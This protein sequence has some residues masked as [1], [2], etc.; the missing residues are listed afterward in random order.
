MSVKTCCKCKVEK[1]IIYFSKNKG[2]KDGFNSRCKEC[3]K[4]HSKIDYERHSTSYKQRAKDYRLAHKEDALFVE[5]NRIASAKSRQKNSSYYKERGV[6]YCKAHP[7]RIKRSQQKYRL[8]N[9]AKYNLY[10]QKRKSS[11]LNFKFACLERVR[12]NKALK[13]GQKTGSAIDNLGCSVEEALVHIETT[14]KPGWTWEDWK[15]KGF[16]ID[17]IIPLASFNL[18]DPTQLKQAFHYTNLQAL[19]WD[20]N[21]S[22]SD[23]IHKEY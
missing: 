11:D 9:K 5:K 18:E 12:L 22:K 19:W 2:N 16:H 1:D 6:E 14:F 8:N 17:H 4:E 13:R 10:S 20:E 7:E 15:Y 23:K 21:M 3:K